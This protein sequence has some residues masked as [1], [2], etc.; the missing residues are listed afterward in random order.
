MRK[1][2]EMEGREGREVKPVK[3]FDSD[4]EAYPA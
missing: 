2:R 4:P 3:S 1:D